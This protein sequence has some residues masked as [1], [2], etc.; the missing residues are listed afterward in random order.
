[1]SDENTTSSPQPVEGDIVATDATPVPAGGNVEVVDL[2]SEME[3][4]YL[5]YAMAVI[6]GRAR[7][8]PRHLRHVRRRLPPRALLQ[9]VRPRRR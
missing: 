1:M 6:I 2:R 5:D 3:R 7:A 4:S 8:P 9:Q